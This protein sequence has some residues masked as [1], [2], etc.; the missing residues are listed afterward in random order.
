MLS[1]PPDASIGFPLKVNSLVDQLRMS[2]THLAQ[3]S[4]GG[5]FLTV[6]QSPCLLF[7]KFRLR[8]NPKRIHGVCE[9]T[10]MNERLILMAKM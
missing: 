1:E 6:N 8:S 7:Q 5:T 4:A 10:C 2:S 3:L 9:F